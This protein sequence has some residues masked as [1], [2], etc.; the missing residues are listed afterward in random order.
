MKNE[1]TAFNA[2]N[3][4][5]KHKNNDNAKVVKLTPKVI[6]SS[7]TE[8]TFLES[9][10]NHIFKRVKEEPGLVFKDGERNLYITKVASQFVGAGI[11]RK[12][13]IKI[14]NEK[15]N[16][17]DHPD[18]LKTL[19]YIYDTQKEKFGKYLS[20][21]DREVIIS[22]KKGSL[23]N[24]VDEKFSTPFIENGVLEN[25]PLLL[26]KVALNSSRPREKDNL[27]ISTLGLISGFLPNVFCIHGDELFSTNL[28]IV[29][30]APYASGKGKASCVLK[31]AKDLIDKFNLE[32]KDKIEE[33][34]LAYNEAKRSKSK[35]PEKPKLRTVII[36][37]DSSSASFKDMIIDND[38]E[39]LVFATEIDSFITVQSNGWGEAMS[40]LL[41]NISTNEDIMFSRK[42]M[43]PQTI[44]SPKLA[45]LF[46]G[47]K[48]G[49]DK[50]VPD[51]EDGSFSRTIFYAYDRE[52]KFDENAFSFEKYKSKKT[53]YD[54]LSKKF[55]ELYIK[56]ES[57]GSLG[58]SLVFR[59]NSE[60]QKILAKLFDKWVES[61]KVIF[62]DGGAAILFRTALMAT[63]IATILT[64]LRLFDNNQID[65][66]LKN[67]TDSQIFIE[68]SQIDF[69]IA[70]CLTNTLRQHIYYVYENLSNGGGSRNDK[71]EKTGEMK[72]YE[73]LPIDLEMKRDELVTEYSHKI[74]V[75]ARAFDKYLAKL[76][77]LGLIS[78]V[79]GKQG[80]YIKKS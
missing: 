60:Q 46:T 76:V 79:I 13:A 32:N 77:K 29:I 63:R 2:T 15:I 17:S 25:S 8:G 50:F 31:I 19:H 72:L 48:S 51:A 27:Y 67:D 73:I 39:G 69:D 53:E 28:S 12:F 36:P 75:K 18:H 52:L 47:T 1:I 45:V 56:L 23:E 55:L 80:Y 6:S 5:N 74:Q 57:I 62:D 21:R 44:K 22:T 11:P 54:F 34:K 40:S 49:V 61:Y 70:I 16:L 3:Y 33:Y 9:R 7:L 10:A 20:Q 38:G 78:R 42:N 41:R 43:E 37:A 30:R 58:K 26:S 65:D 35:L 64:V 68:S 71:S 66:L 59:W 4:L 14:L 24:E